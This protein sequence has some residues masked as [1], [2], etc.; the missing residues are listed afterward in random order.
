MEDLEVM[1]GF[2]GSQGQG[3]WSGVGERGREGERG[4]MQ[5]W[6]FGVYFTGVIECYLF[7]LIDGNFLAR[8]IITLDSEI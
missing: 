8:F 4:G 1:W 6:F 2:E 7:K 3:E 5:F